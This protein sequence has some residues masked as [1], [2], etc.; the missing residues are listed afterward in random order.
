MPLGVPAEPVPDA[1]PINNPVPQSSYDQLNTTGS[2]AG[3][4]GRSSVADLA[5]QIKTLC[6]ILDAHPD[7]SVSY[8]P[9]LPN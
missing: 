7:F 2:S 1:A 8:P 5:R 4:T 6:A 9:E 3:T